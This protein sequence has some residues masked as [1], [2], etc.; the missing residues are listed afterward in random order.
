MRTMSPISKDES[1]AV[2]LEVIIT[3]MTI[4]TSDRLITPVSVKVAVAGPPIQSV[5]ELGV[6]IRGAAR[7]GRVP[8]CR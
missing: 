7:D 8:H 6:Q 3:E 1:L 5:V 4:V 2:T